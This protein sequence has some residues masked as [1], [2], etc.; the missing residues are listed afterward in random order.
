MARAHD[1]RRLALTEEAITILFCLVDDAYTL[2][3]P[4][5]KSSES[6]KRL[7]DSEV[8]TLSFLQQLRG[9]ES[10]YASRWRCFAALKGVFGMDGTLATT[11]VGLV[12][13]IATKI[14]AY[15]YAFLVNRRLNRPQGRIKELWA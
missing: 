6:I 15:T 3:N 12:T 8:I 11:L 4:R 2:L 9:V 1:T 13:R 7:S 14:R 5:A 10:E